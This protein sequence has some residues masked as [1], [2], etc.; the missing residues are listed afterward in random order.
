[1]KSTASLGGFGECC[2]C[3]DFSSFDCDECY[4]F[5]VDLQVDKVI[6]KKWETKIEARDKIGE[7]VEEGEYNKGM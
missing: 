1:M 6:E 2:E 7:G 3:G 4:S 5:F